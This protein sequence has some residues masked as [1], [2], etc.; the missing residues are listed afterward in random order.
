MPPDALDDPTEEDSTLK[1]CANCR[2][3]RVELRSKPLDTA[4]DTV[5][6]FEDEDQSFYFCMSKAGPFS[7]KEIGFSPVLCDAYE[8]PKGKGSIGAELDALMARASLRAK[9]DEER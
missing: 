4:F 7:G 3:H 6:A 8:S 5:V 1:S 2:H 9:K